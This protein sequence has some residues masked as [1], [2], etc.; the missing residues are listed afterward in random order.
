MVSPCHSD[1]NLAQLSH[2]QKN[3]KTNQKKNI[4]QAEEKQEKRAQRVVASVIAAHRYCLLLLLWELGSDPL[5]AGSGRPRRLPRPIQYPNRTPYS[6][7]SNAKLPPP[8]D[9]Q[10]PQ[11]KQAPAEASTVGAFLLL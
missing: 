11:E 9:S 4:F 3:K 7:H 8:H 6:F 1:S 2:Q 5:F 10:S